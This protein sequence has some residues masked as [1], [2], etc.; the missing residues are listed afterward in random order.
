MALPTCCCDVAPAGLL[1]A[2]PEGCVGCCEAAA[3]SRSKQM[4]AEP[5][6]VLALPSTSAAGAC[7]RG[8]AD[9][10]CCKPDP[11][12]SS[13]A[14]A[15]GA[16]SP[17]GPPAADCAAV[18]AAVSAPAAGSSAPRLATR[19][20]LLLAASVG[21]S[22]VWTR[23]GSPEAAAREADSCAS[24]AS[25]ALTLQQVRRLPCASRQGSNCPRSMWSWQPKPAQC[26]S[27]ADSGVRAWLQQRNG[28]RDI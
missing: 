15:G 4:W 10:P 25:R 28:L 8:T 24:V 18:C 19:G 1:L 13:C 26:A 16:E 17:A 14:S 5:E 3:A 12:A 2:A 7:S 23:G 9:S 6:P 11:D 22:A 20:W 21:S 27:Q